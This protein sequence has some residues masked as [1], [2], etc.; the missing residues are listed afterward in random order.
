M[1]NNL[2][3]I[4]QFGDE[5]ASATSKI[6]AAP[7]LKNPS[8]QELRTSHTFLL[9][10]AW[11]CI[12]QLANGMHFLPPLALEGYLTSLESYYTFILNDSDRMLSGS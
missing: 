3:K 12:K 11:R 5:I 8:F 7:Q 10:G 9:D 6:K 2:P 4:E 1:H